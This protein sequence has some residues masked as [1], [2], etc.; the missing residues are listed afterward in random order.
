[1]DEAISPYVEIDAANPLAHHFDGDAVYEVHACPEHAP[2]LSRAS[3]PAQ[4]RDVQYGASDLA[5]RYFAH[6]SQHL[7][8]I[9]WKP[10]IS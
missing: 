6:V 9:I 8:R 2:H 5:A 3:S 10:A 7:Q 4:P 1:M